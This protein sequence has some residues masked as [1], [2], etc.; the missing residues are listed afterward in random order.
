[1]LTIFSAPKP[2]Q[3]HIGVIQNNAIQSWRLACPD[4]EVILFGGE[5]G[6]AEVASRLGLR[7]LPD[8]DCN[9]YG[10]PLVSSIFN[11]A[12]NVAS[13]QTM[14]YVNADIIL[15]SDFLPAV[16]RAPKRLFLMVGQRWDLEVKQPVDFSDQ[17]WERKLRARLTEEGKLHAETGMDYFLFHRGFYDS[18]PPFALGRTAWDNW[19]VYRARSLRIPVIDVTKAVTI[20]HQDH[21]YAHVLEGKTGAIM[22]SEAKRNQE[23]LGRKDNSLGINQATWTLTPRGLRRAIT[24]KHLYYQWEVLPVLFPLLR[25]LG[26][27]KKIMIAC[28]R[29]IRLKLGIPRD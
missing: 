13:H 19:L 22:G 27:P 1:M 6:T 24:V 8:I 25:F 10:T 12:Q 14:C 23:L 29:A 9:E 20:I 26:I 18:I 7:H 28:S 5:E 4:S 2:F 11:I 21:D 17:D 3:G 15:M 16:Q